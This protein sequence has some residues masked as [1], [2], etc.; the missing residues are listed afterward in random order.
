VEF[1][2]GHNYNEKTMG[3]RPVYLATRGRNRFQNQPHYVHLSLPLDLHSAPFLPN[4]YYSSI[5]EN[6]DYSPLKNRPDLD[7]TSKKGSSQDPDSKNG[8]DPHA[9]FKD[10]CE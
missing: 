7:L 2:T 3:V 8:P 1:P 4:R 5:L 6:P 9:Y 10:S